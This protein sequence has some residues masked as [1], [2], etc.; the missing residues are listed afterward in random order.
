M[1]TEKL[2]AL[3]H[4]AHGSLVVGVGMVF[5]AAKV[6]ADYYCKHGKAK[7]APP[8]AEVTAAP[9]PPAATV[10]TQAPTPTPTAAPTP[11]PTAAPAA[12]PGDVD[13]SLGSSTASQAPGSDSMVERADDGASPSGDAPDARADSSG[14]DASAAGDDDAVAPGTGFVSAADAGEAAAA[15]ARG[16]HRPR[17]A[18]RAGRG[19]R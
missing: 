1:E 12:A 14:S 13:P 16:G 15:G 8:D 9:P 4:I 11:A 3:T 19:G 2:V 17:T 18:T 7:P 5:M 10:A 6:D